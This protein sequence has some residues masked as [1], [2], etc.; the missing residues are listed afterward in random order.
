M[1]ENECDDLFGDDP[2]GDPAPE[3]SGDPAPPVPAADP[4][5][6]PNSD[7]RVNDL[8]AAFRREQARANKAEAALAKLNPQAPTAGQPEAGSAPAAGQLEEYLSLA[9]ESARE[10]LFKSIPELAEAGLTASDIA[11]T[12]VEEMR[13]SALGHQKLIQGIAT[14][15]RQNVLAEH[16][17]TADI[18]GSGARSEPKDWSLMPKDEF[19]KAVA[20][21]LQ[22]R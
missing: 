1:P 7:K 16:G 19:E 6:D 20:A 14:R 18:G 11:G 13:A 5:A 9:R 21:A 2:A 8:M 3:R 17:L 4:K 22:G 12:S 15:T 10:Q